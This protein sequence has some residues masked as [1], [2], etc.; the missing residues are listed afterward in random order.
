LFIIG[1]SEQAPK[2]PV[3][4]AMPGES[5]SIVDLSPNGTGAETMAIIP[6][7]MLP[8]LC[9]LEMIDVQPSVSPLSTSVIDL[10]VQWLER[11]PL[12][13]RPPPL[14]FTIRYGP[15]IRKLVDDNSEPLDIIPGYETI[16]RTVPKVPEMPMLPDPTREMNITGVQRGS[17]LKIQIC[18]VFD[19]N[20]EPLVQWDSA[21]TNRI[22]L[23]ALEPF[24]EAEQAALQTTTDMSPLD[25]QD[26]EAIDMSP[27][28]PVLI[29]VEP[30]IQGSND[31]IDDVPPLVIAVDV[32]QKSSPAVYWLTVTAGV[33][34]M[35]LTAML[36]FAFLRRA[37]NSRRLVKGLPMHEKQMVIVNTLPTFTKFPP[38]SF[39]E[40]VKVP[41]P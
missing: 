28:A 17:L 16:F 13:A 19:P 11:Q 27:V 6:Q 9:D 15:I 41:L 38:P 23:A 12:P 10:Q 5:I 20:S 14:Y 39:N 1:Q 29:P 30:A 22:D 3:A 25:I 31:E 32:E 7:A 4:E 40:V 36:V 37:C 24:L 34:L 2:A 21:L 35:V 26:A 33:L 8:P 18:A